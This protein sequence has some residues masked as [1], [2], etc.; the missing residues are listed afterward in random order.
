MRAIICLLAAVLTLCFSFPL[1]A[2]RIK[3]LA[4]VEGVRDNQLLGYGV[5]VGLNGTGDSTKSDYTIMSIVNMMRNFGITVNVN[6]I[7]PKNV[8]AVIVT[9]KLPAFAKPGDTIDINV[10]SVGDAKSIQGG[11]LLQ[12]PLQAANGDVYA[13]AQGPVSIGGYSAGG[14]GGGQQKNHPTAGMVSNGAIVERG[15]NTALTSDGILRLSLNKPDF[16]TAD[17]VANRIN[18]VWGGIAIASDA[19]TVSVNIPGGGQDIVG[20]IASLEEISVDPDQAAKVI[21]NERT[22]TVVMG[23]NVG[24]SE[25]AVSQ[26]GLTVTITK[27]TDVSQ[28]GPFAPGQTVVTG[29]TETDVREEKVNLIVLPTS[30]KVSDVVTALNAAGAT[31]RDIMTIL[32]AMQ[33]AGALHAVIEM[34]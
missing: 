23:G 4:K 20:F 1:E 24:I 19:G 33:A 29:N 22:G 15:T 18:S 9:A 34:I 16:T 3:D 26:G 28:P 7:K 6:D 21:L 25:V 17:R 13:V 11:V 27:S 14:G 30:T 8:A 12:S 32:Q 10:A 31:P 5:V 2:A